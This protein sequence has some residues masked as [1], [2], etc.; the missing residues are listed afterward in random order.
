MTAYPI[1]RKEAEAVSVTRRVRIPTGL[2]CNILC[3]FCYYGDE[4][5]SSDYTFKQIASML[6]LAREFGV[7]DIDFS[8]GEPTARKDFPDLVALARDKGFRR[9]CVITNGL[10][11]ANRNVVGALAGQGLN[12]VLI[13][14]HGADEETSARL[15]GKTGMFGKVAQALDNIAE[16]G[17]RLR[18]NTVVNRVNMEKLPNIAA[19]IAGHY[20]AAANFICFNDWINAAPATEGMAVR[21]SEAAPYLKAAIDRLEVAAGRVTV[22]YI[23]FCQMEGY[24]RHVSNLLQ[25]TCDGDEWLDSI[26]RV[27]TDVDRPE[28]FAA[29]KDSLNDAW[30]TLGGEMGGGLCEAELDALASTGGDAAFTEITPDNALAAHVVDNFIK[31]QSYVKV[32][33]CAD[34]EYDSLCDGLHKS[35]ADFIGTDELIPTSTDNAP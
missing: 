15:S 27:V 4:L 11:L 17:L 22:R 24:G 26:K 23:P 19:F 2:T 34:C 25:N 31:R 9:V 14:V 6:N 12:E 29:Y 28:A 32:P 10:H 20:P 30:R 13:S 8:G 33:S 1:T 7:R 35:Y 5:N 18:T 3:P 16:A 21:Y